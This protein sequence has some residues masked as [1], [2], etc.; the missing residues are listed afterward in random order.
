MVCG[1]RVCVC[2]GVGTDVLFNVLF[3]DVSSM[4]V[5]GWGGVCAWSVMCRFI[6][7]GLFYRSLL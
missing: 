1:V 3:N 6:C 4:V 5:R 2:Q 7:I